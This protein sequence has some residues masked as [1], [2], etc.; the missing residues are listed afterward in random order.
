MVRR[1]RIGQPYTDSDFWL[2]YL[3]NCSRAIKKK[4][5]IS[6]TSTCL[7]NTATDS[8]HVQVGQNPLIQ[9]LH[10][11]NQKIAGALV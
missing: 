9:L 7:K 8:I 10:F 4:L 1:L 6:L 3:L 2:Y 11:I 5:I